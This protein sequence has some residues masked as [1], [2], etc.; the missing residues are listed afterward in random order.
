MV[1]D[2]AIIMQRVLTDRSSV[3]SNWR[4]LADIASWRHEFLAV[5]DATE[6]DAEMTGVVDRTLER[7]ALLRADPCWSAHRVRYLEDRPG[8][9]ASLSGHLDGRRVTQ[10]V[11]GEPGSD[12]CLRPVATAWRVR[13]RCRESNSQSSLRSTE[14]PDTEFRVGGE[15]LRDEAAYRVGVPGSGHAR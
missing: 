12:I 7:M 6:A 1:A 11:R 9:P 8:E 2:D 13:R 10:V 4:L 15:R 5:D 14:T 3:A